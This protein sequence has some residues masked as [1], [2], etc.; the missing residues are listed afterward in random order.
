MF[1]HS[2]IWSAL[3]KIA[4]NNRLS[5]S[6]LSKRAGLDPTSFNKS[7]RTTGN[8]RLRWPST[9]SVAKVLDCTN[10]T[11]EEFAALLLGR[12]PQ[13]SVSSKLPVMSFRQASQGVN[14]DD[15][16]FP[17]GPDWKEVS[18]PQVADRYAY[19]LEVA[20]DRLLPV[21]R[22]GDV[23]VMSPDNEVHPGD[24]VVIRKQNGE[25]SVA[26][27]R[28]HGASSIEF[29]TL[30]PSVDSWHV[31]TRDIDWISR[32]VWASQ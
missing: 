12:D 3:D 29:T 31:N 26:V 15:A 11:V 21:Y 20:D 5:I 28:S 24:R 4:E 10:T 16:G 7:K 17:T 19:A 23:I 2:E 27:L 1:T 32:I 9:E 8:G 25:L 14:F 22:R 18:F 6:G 13:E 30:S